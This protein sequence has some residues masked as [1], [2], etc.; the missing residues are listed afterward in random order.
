[1]TDRQ[2]EAFAAFARFLNGDP[3]ACCGAIFQIAD[4]LTDAGFA[5]PDVVRMLRNVADKLE[6]HYA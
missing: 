1:M 5:G 3:K 6:E 2:E 4:H